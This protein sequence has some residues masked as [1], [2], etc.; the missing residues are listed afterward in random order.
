[1]KKIKVILSTRGPLHLIKSAEYLCRYVDIRVIQGWIPKWWNAWLIFFA[2]KIVGR[3]L[4]NSFK[5]RTPTCLKGRNISIGLPEF[6]DWFCKVSH[7]CPTTLST[8]WTTCMY[9]ELSCLYIKNADILHVRSGS[10]GSAIRFAKNK[11]MKIIVDHSIAHP[12]FMNDNLSE[13]YKEYGV[14]FDMNMQNPFW[15]NI[16]RECEQGDVVLVNSNFVKNTFV[17]NGF[18]PDK[19]KVVYLGVR[20]DFWSLKSDY[21]ISKGQ[22]EILFTGGFGFRKGG[23]YILAALCELDKQNVKYHMTVV[24]DSNGSKPLLK[25]YSP[26]NITFVSTV[27]QDELKRY[28][29]D[30]DIYLFPSLCEGCASSGMEAMAAGLPVI[31]TIE[32]GLPIDDMVDGIIV[33]SKDTNEIV[34]KIKLLM[35]DE[36]LRKSLGIHAAKKIKDNYTWDKYAKSVYEIY[37]ELLS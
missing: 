24:G 10:G 17:N 11:G 37:K 30:S 12:N 5:K 33:S 35:S 28:L 29:A 31:A 13:E 32:S 18:N 34:E 23:E 15:N 9:G 25:K 2:S 1:M 20:E 6:F 19:I 3:D 4:K 14:P 26:S 7:I 8:Y 22:V 27:P 16:V 21:N 36:S